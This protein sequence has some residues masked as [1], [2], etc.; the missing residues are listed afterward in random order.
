MESGIGRR[1]AAVQP[2]PGATALNVADGPSDEQGGA[3]DAVDRAFAS[4]MA[5]ERVHKQIGGG[6]H[7]QH[8]A[9]VVAA[10]ELGPAAFGKGLAEIHVHLG[11]AGAGGGPLQDVAAAHAD[12]GFNQVKACRGDERAF[13]NV[14]EERRGEEIGPARG[15]AGDGRSGGARSRG[16]K[17]NGRRR[18]RRRGPERRNGGGGGGGGGSRARRPKA[19]GGGGGGPGAGPCASASKE[20]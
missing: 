9:G 5:R 13:G 17:R 14:E 10:D 2:D 7:R 4:Q 3:E 1:Q 8:A 19:G 11:G 20:S 18:G 6:V 12:R 15:L 16:Q